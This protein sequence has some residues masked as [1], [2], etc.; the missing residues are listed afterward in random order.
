[1]TADKGKEF[2]L[3]PEIAKLSDKISKDPSSKLFVPLAEEYR[4][5]GML[6]EAIQVLSDGLKANPNYM[7]ARVS[8]GKILLEKGN[9]NE[10]REEMEK[11]VQTIP[12]NLFAHKKL[13]EIFQSTGDRE[14]L[15][16]EYRIIFSLSPNDKDVKNAIDKLERETLPRPA[17]EIP[18]KPRILKETEI[19]SGL[20]EP[21]H[22]VPPSVEELPSK[23]ELMRPDIPYSEEES[24]YVFSESP[25]ELVPP[26]QDRTEK[27]EEL[28]EEAIEETYLPGTEDIEKEKEGEA[29]YEIPDEAITPEE[30]G[31]DIPIKMTPVSEVPRTKEMERLESLISTAITHKEPPVETAVPKEEVREDSGK[32]GKTEEL[33]TETLA[34]LY[35]KQGQY[36]KAHEIYQQILLSDPDNM[37]VRQKQEELI[38]LINIMTMKDSGKGKDF[39]KGVKISKLEAWLENIKGRRR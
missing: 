13:A 24:P 17:E 23:E 19:K 22:D 36:D 30:L 2:E 37:P 14:N 27:K 20:P 26:I 10:A 38:F 15:L 5:M 18:Q 4:K 8:L 1:M 12:D 32:S 34:E 6:D 31:I 21:E 29:V 25:E 11:V 3:S 9:I 33:A 16:K 35:I 7:S 28:I 39:G